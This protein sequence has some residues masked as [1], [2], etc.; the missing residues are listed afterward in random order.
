MND[1]TTTD[2]VD[3]SAPYRDASRPTDERV[4]DLM[5]RMSLDEK[6]GQLGSL[7]VFQVADTK[8]FD[9]DRAA[10]LLANGLGHLTR[11]SGASSYPSRVAA[12]VTNELQRHLVDHTRL[13]IP[14]IVHEEIC[15]GL[16]ART[17]TTFP[18]AIGVA[19]TFRP[20]HNRA[21]AD[22]IRRQMRSMGAHQGL[23]PV[24]DVC[25]DPRWG[26][27]EETYGEDAH[28]VSRMGVAF[29]RGL[30]GDDLR[31]G[32]AAT[33]KHFVGY[34]ASEGGMNWAPA[35]VP[36][37]QLLDVYLRPFEAAVREAGLASI[38]N[39]Y[40]ELD[41][42]P[43]GANHW[44]LTELLRDTWGFDGTVVADYFAV[45]QLFE[46]HRVAADP[47]AAAALAMASGIDIE[48]PGV[49]CYADPIRRAIADGLLPM[50]TVDEAVRRAL[51][52]KFRLGLFETP[53]VDL[54]TVDLETRTPPQLDLSLEIARDSLVLLRNASVLPL[55]DTTRV[56]VI[57]PNADEARHLF[58]DYSYLAHVESLQE[59]LDS[60]RN[61]F[62]MPLDHG[63]GIDSD[64]ELGHVATVLAAMRDRLPDCE[65]VHEQGCG[66]TD[67]DR[68][69][70]DAAVAAASESDVAIM[71]MGEK[72]GLTDDCTS[73]E[74]R[75]VADLGLPG[76]QEDL[77]LAVAATG[78][79]VVLVLICGRPIGSPAVHE[80][81][82]A[83]I[84]GWFPGE[85][86]GEAIADVLTGVASPGGRLPVTYPRHVGQVPTFYG[87]K[88]SGGRSHWK[89]EYV[90]MTNAPLHPFGHGL[91]YST[92][93]IVPEP[94]LPATVGVDDIVDVTVVVTN[95]GARRADEVLQLYSR[96]PVAPITRPVLELQDFLR[97][98][99][100]PG[101]SERVTFH[102]PVD[103][104]GYT[105][106]DMHHIVDPGEIELFVGRSSA[107]LVKAGSVLVT[108]D[109]PT[110]RRRR[111]PPPATIG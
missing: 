109:G 35:N 101:A 81:A 66:L 60:G 47:A 95:T 16:M 55:A 8:G 28:L 102:V 39:G 42:V 88:V 97:V 52:T 91:T 65:I 105:G 40:H 54:E 44:L 32:V 61:I 36:P 29:V 93:E 6:L 22:T 15:S 4:A 79:P 86:G 67:P 104:F 18:Q 110:P 25:R 106:V 17:A 23:S 24:L 30:Q 100:H 53:Y 89:G 38:M 37:R 48:L 58:G 68:S 72:G 10:P 43:C 64:I 5:A 19:A 75:D 103:A 12:E 87:H 73:G 96:D 11:M 99:I 31:E 13:G 76:V 90:D 3:P 111:L 82:A 107:D 46:Y 69:G 108:A 84:V 14:A 74:S 41:G 51:D 80:A 20:E 50:A 59:V 49:D 77:V 71:V 57:G 33:A 45:R 27:L 94:A 70:F 62:S 85:R 92:T 98:R 63:V 83:V 56:A 34:G 9:A 78:T 21:M 26:R 2:P 7:W 1:S